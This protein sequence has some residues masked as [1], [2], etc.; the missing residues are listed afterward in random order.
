MARSGRAPEPA[1]APGPGDDEPV[2]VRVP[3]TLA[4]ATPDGEVGTA[5]GSTV[6]ISR[7]GARI[8]HGGFSPDRAAGSPLVVV[9][10]DTAGVAIVARRVGRQEPETEHLSFLPLDDE[11]RDV[12]NRLTGRDPP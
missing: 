6:T 11:Q 10:F 8:R 2:P 3:V 4:A 1:A 5:V 12:V 7:A 9:V